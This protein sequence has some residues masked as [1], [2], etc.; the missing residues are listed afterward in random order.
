[1]LYLGLGDGG[2]SFDP[3]DNAQDG[4]TLLGKLIRI[5]V[6]PVHGAYA[7]PPD[8]PFLGDA[9]VHDEIWALGLRNPWRIAFDRATGDLYIADVGQ[10]EFEE[11]NHQPAGS[12]G[13]RNYGRAWRV[14]VRRAAA[15]AIRVFTCRWPSTTTARAVPSPAARCTGASTTPISPAL[16]CSA[17]SAPA[18]SGACAATGTSGP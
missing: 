15:I 16:T 13:G 9:A 17:T 11:I 18:G 6:D 4:G 12:G 7:I 8:N 14:R 2:G 3:D 5:D 10:N 1:M